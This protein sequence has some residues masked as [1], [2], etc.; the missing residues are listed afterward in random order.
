MDCQV[1]MEHLMEA[2]ANILQVSHCADC[3]EVTLHLNGTMHLIRCESR[4]LRRE[5]AIGR[6]EVDY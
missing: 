2:E 4:A 6:F 1:D 5:W 3:A